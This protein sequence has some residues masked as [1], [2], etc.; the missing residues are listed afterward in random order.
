MEF[1][2]GNTFGATVF[3]SYAAF[4]LSYAMI[5]IPGTGILA[6]RMVFTIV[7]LTIANHGIAYMDAATGRLRPE[8]SQ[9]LA[10]FCWAWFILTVIYTVA[11]TRSS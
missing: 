6:C 1:V 10:M 4:N 3:P 11:A 8:F 2:A 5:F 7:D 9:A